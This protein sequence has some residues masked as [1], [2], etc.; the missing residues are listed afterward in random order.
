MV[1]NL[2]KGQ[3]I[4]VTK[5]NVG[6]SKIKVGLGWDQ[7]SQK[8]VA[9]S[10]DS[11]Q[12]KGFMNKF[13]KAIKSAGDAVKNAIPIDCD[14]SVFLLDENGRLQRSSNLI[15]FGNKRSN[16]GSVIHQGDNVT[17]QGEGDDEVIN[18]DLSKVPSDV[19]QLIFV[20]NIYQAKSKG[21]H[22][23]MINNAF[24]RIV[25]ERNGEEIIRF[26]LSSDYD[27]KTG[28]LIG[29]LYRRNAEWKFDA[30]GEGTLDGGL[31]DMK[32]RYQ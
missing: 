3:K 6:I 11:L 14:A 28:L 27:G 18:V 5:G 7:A 2:Q 32:R 10:D 31:E 30:L 9:G 15:Y 22:F 26:N 1:V 21:Q 23:G 12:G 13:N 8:K 29:K 20:V 25:D 16:C 17:G 4:D 24:I 19:Q